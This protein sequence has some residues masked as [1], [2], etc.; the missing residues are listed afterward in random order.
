ML[1]MLRKHVAAFVL[2]DRQVRRDHVIIIIAVD[3]VASAT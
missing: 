3:V 1:K 2:F